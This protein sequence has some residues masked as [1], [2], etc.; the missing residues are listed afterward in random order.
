MGQALLVLAVLVLAVLVLAVLVL[1]VGLCLHAVLVLG[2]LWLLEV[3]IA[4]IAVM[5]FRLWLG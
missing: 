1:A 5:L 4:V 3:R 2:W